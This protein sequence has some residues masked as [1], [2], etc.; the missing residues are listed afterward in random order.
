MACRVDCIAVT[1]DADGAASK[2]GAYWAEPGRQEVNR[3]AT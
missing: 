1:N 2:S 3:I